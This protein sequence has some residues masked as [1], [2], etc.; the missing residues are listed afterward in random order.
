MKHSTFLLATCL[1]VLTTSPASAG[2]REQ[3]VT[4]CLLEAKALVAPG[5]RV[6]FNRFRG[7]HDR[8]VELKIGNGK[9]FDKYHCEIDED[10]VEIT[11]INGQPLAPMTADAG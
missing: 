6:K 7:R 9:G 10:I 2:E 11:T 5:T 4:H 1:T 8:I 3:R